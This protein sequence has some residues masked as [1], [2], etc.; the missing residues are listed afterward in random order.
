MSMSLYL[1]NVNDLLSALPESAAAADARQ[2]AAAAATAESLEDLDAAL[3]GV[4]QGWL[5]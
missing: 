5:T 4:V 2:L 3:S 1:P